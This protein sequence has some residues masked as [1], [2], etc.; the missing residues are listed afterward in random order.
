MEEG[1]ALA[2]HQG[3]SSKPSGATANIQNENSLQPEPSKEEEDL[4][5]RHNRKIN[6]KVKGKEIEVPSFKDALVSVGTITAHAE[7]VPDLLEYDKGPLGKENADI[8]G[9]PSI[10]ISDE[11]KVCIWKPWSTSIIICVIGRSFGHS[12]LIHKLET[13]WKPL[14]KMM[15]MDLGDHFWLIRFNSHSDMTKVLNE[16]PWFIGPHYVTIRK[17][18]PEFDTST[19][20]VSTSVVWVRL[21][22]LPVE[23]YD[24][25][26]LLK[27]GAKV[28]KLLKIDLRTESNEKVR[29]A[30]LCVQVDLS[31]ALVSRVRVGNHIQKVS[32]EGIPS[33]CF[34]CGLTG[35][36]IQNCNPSPPKPTTTPSTEDAKFGEWML[37]TNKNKDRKRGNLQSKVETKPGA[38]KIPMRWNRKDCNSSFEEGAKLQITN[39]TTSSSQMQTKSSSTNSVPLVPTP[40]TLISSEPLLPTPCIVTINHP[41]TP[42]VPQSLLADYARV[43]SPESKLCGL[44]VGA[45]PP[46]HPETSR[47]CLGLLGRSPSRSLGE[48]ILILSHSKST[49]LSPSGGGDLP[50]RPIHI[51]RRSSS[52]LHPTELDIHPIQPSSPKQQSFSGPH[53]CGN[54][55]PSVPP[56]TNGV[57]LPGRLSESVSH[58][59]AAQ[60]SPP[61]NSN[62]KPK[63]GQRPRRVLQSARICSTTSLSEAKSKKHKPIRIQTKGAASPHFRRHFNDLVRDHHPTFVIIAETRIA[64]SRAKDLS[65]GLGFSHSFVVDSVGFSGGLWL[66]W[67]DDVFRCDALAITRQEIH[68]SVQVHSNSTPFILSAIYACPDLDIRKELWENLCVLADNHNEPWLMMGDFNVILFSNEKFGGRPINWSRASRFKDCIDYCGMVDLGF[69]GSRFT[70]T[71]RRL[72]G[73]IIRERLDRCLAN[74]EWSLAF[75]EASVKHLARVHSDHCPI[76]LNSDSPLSLA[77]D[78]PFRLLGKTVSSAPVAALADKSVS[79]TLEQLFE[80]LGSTSR[81]ESTSSTESETEF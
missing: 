69:S 29:F 74:A 71:N 78:R 24:K 28:G 35:H 73:G 31:T 6:D 67:N 38:S 5:E 80:L 64:G 68:A 76:L 34:K 8:D 66:L 2:G 32:Y 58:P 65:E 16:G 22:G 13:M 4:L 45:L 53:P 55:S 75:P 61:G 9:I 26:M 57:P 23:F 79:S 56:S 11:D 72:A 15:C 51:L 70:W 59:G 27:I 20:K 63:P 43:V 21:P 3:S 36:K 54:P 41:L 10:A 37:V 1:Q 62:E 52:P 81:L 47:S 33:I 7:M 17:W 12:Y 18:E 39:G 48:H 30:R 42:P 60:C 46:V 25:E 19:A 44:S 50:D 14:E 40:P 49:V 77:L